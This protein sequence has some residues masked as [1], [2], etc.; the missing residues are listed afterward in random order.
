[1]R[2]YL[3]TLKLVLDQGTWLESRTGIRRI[4][5][6]GVSMRFVQNFLIEDRP[7]SSEED[8]RISLV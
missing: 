3:D 5:F 1:M 8:H 4:S 7:I 2:Q 6:P